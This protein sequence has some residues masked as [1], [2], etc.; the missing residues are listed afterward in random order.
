M[1]AVS[2]TKHSTSLMIWLAMLASVAFLF[3]GCASFDKAKETAERSVPEFHSRLNSERY[4]DIYAE[5]D[6][7]FKK[8]AS[9]E[10]VEKFLRAVH[11][12]LGK[13]KAANQV[14]YL[15]SMGSDAAV[16]LTYET[17]FA[18]GKATEQFVWRVKDNRA[19]LLNYNINSA[20]LITK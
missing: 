17:T 12:K 15:V 19:A 20:D 18:E 8:S 3:S 16:T 11:Q 1:R 10:G 4:S 14:S 6:E 7:D 2:L 5:A 13:V 9:Q